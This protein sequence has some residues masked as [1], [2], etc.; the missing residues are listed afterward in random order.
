MKGIESVMPNSL[1]Y[2]YIASVAFGA[3]RLLNNTRI[4]FNPC[5]WENAAL[6]F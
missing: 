4:T 2:N 3:T 6:N 5:P 1:T